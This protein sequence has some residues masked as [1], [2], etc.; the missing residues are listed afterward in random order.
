M[1]AF[2]LNEGASLSAW[3]VSLDGLLADYSL[4]LHLTVALA[5]MVLFM[6]ALALIIKAR[7]ASN[8]LLWLCSRDVLCAVGCAAVV[9]AF[10]GFFFF[11]G[12]AF[13]RAMCGPSH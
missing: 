7:G 3:L 6:S 4:A 10:P 13:N 12:R 2:L 8:E 11:I 5:C 9:L 1:N